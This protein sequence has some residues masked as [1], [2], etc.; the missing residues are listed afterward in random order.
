MKRW[1]IILILVFNLTSL[2]L[3]QETKSV[4]EEGKLLFRLEKA[5]WYGTDDFLARFSNKR[6]SIGGYLSYV[7]ENDQVVN[8]FF[9]RDQPSHIFVRYYF[10]SLPGN[11]P[12]E[13]D[14]LDHTASQLENDL[15]AIR[16]D[17]SRQILENPDKFF[18]FYENTAMNLIPLIEGDK[19]KVFILTASE[20]PHVVMIGNDYL[21]TYNHD[22]KLIKK[23]QLHISLLRYPYT[24]GDPENKMSTTYHTHVIS[25]YI[26]STDICTLLLYKDFVEWKQHHVIGKKH[27]SIFDLEKEDLVIMT[28]KAWNKLNKLQRK[29]K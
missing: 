9:N 13:I 19:R 10:D 22:N 27:V 12:V 20:I 7:N 3:G 24:S 26:N 4:L 6:D 29:K 5:S 28:K 11:K 25:D 17:A 16:Q 2:L 23:E 15:I 14:S 21:L 8:I 1:G 18:S